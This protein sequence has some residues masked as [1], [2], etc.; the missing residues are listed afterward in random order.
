MRLSQRPLLACELGNFEEFFFF[1]AGV[2]MK[3]LSAVLTLR[4]SAMI[5]VFPDFF[6]G[7]DLFG[8]T[9]SNIARAIE[10]LPGVNAATHYRTKFEKSRPV[11]SAVSVRTGSG[12]ARTE[13]TGRIAVPPPAKR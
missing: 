10:S 9:E 1:F 6:T 7:D 4:S 2:W 5:K 3:V 12:S 11:E 8:L 13:P